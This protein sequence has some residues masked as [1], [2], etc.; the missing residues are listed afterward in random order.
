VQAGAGG[1]TVFGGGTGDV[2]CTVLSYSVIDSG[3]KN[4]AARFDRLS[5]RIPNL[6]GFS[7][8]TK[9]FTFSIL[10]KLGIFTFLLSFFSKYV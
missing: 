8:L 2:G 1:R 10:L 4:T 5:A 6:F 7:F 3:E 9:I